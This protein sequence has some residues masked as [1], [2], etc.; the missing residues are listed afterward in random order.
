MKLAKRTGRRSEIFLATKFGLYYQP[1]RFS[2]ADL[3]YVRASIK[4]SLKRLGTDH[5]DFFYLHRPDLKV[6]IGHTVGEMAK[7]VK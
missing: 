1:N 7:L 4:R 6:P 5:V 3:E 2:R